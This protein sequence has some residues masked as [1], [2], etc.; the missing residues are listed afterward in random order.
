MSFYVY[1]RRWENE[2]FSFKGVCY[3]NSKEEAILGITIDNKLNIDSHIGKMS[4]TSAQKLNALSRISTFLN[5]D[6]KS[7]ILNAMIKSQFSYC[8]L[9]WMFSSQQSNN[10]IK[11]AH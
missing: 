9:I 8:P 6:K 4:K 10:L 5:K 1:W 7:I 2:T 3:K 11:K